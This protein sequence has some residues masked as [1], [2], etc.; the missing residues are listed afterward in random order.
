M[1]EKCWRVKTNILQLKTKVMCIVTNSRQIRVE[2]LF[3]KVKIQLLLLWLREVVF[4]RSS[5]TKFSFFHSL[6][7]HEGFARIFHVAGNFLQDFVYWPN[8]LSETSVKDAWFF[9]VSQK[10]CL[11]LWKQHA[12]FLRKVNQGR[13][14]TRD[15]LK[16]R[17]QRLQT[18]DNKPS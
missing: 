4:E 3:Q 15:N 16:K 9:H 10:V 6:N 1:L 5:K 13:K 18:L 7:L 17:K 11:H 8:F 14:L 2:C 12:S